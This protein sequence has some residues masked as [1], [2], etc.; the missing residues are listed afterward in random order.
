MLLGLWP[1][2]LLVHFRVK[3]VRSHRLALVVQLLVAVTLAVFVL[4]LGYGFSGSFRRLRD[5]RFVSCT[6]SGIPPRFPVA[7]REGGN[8]FADSA[9]GDLRVPLPKDYLLGIDLQK[10]EFE[11]KKWSY[12]AGEWR[13]GG[14]WYFYLY[15]AAI[16]EPIGTW[17]LTFLALCR[18][19]V[20]SS[21]TSPLRFELMLLL[22]LA[23]VIV[24]VSSQTGFS[25]HPRYSLLAYPYWF[26]LVSRVAFLFRRRTCAVQ[27]VIVGSVLLS[28]VSSVICY[29]HSLSYFNESVGGPRNGHYFLGARDIDS[30]LDWGQDLL[31]LKDWCARH[32]DRSIIRL[33]YN[34]PISPAVAGIRCDETLPQGHSPWSVMSIGCFDSNDFGRELVRWPEPTDHVSYSIHVF[35]GDFS[36]EYRTPGSPR[37]SPPHVQLR[38]SNSNFPPAP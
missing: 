33:E 10:S 31:Y 13:F 21:R 26:I 34:G 17:V 25:H 5:Y 35:Y 27:A 38:S 23:A 9:L 6:F 3:S 14:W 37:E 24:V 36:F 7:S 18:G 16:K 29:P 11:D 12:L 8:L 22:P 28:T 20:S 32:P 19:R 4:N 1:M 15:A 30:C 2:L